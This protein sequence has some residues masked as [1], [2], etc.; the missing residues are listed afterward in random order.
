MK[1]VRGRSRHRA[2]TVGAMYTVDPEFPRRSHAD[3]VAVVHAVSPDLARE[4]RGRGF[5]V[6]YDAGFDLAA[7][8]RAVVGPVAAGVAEVMSMPLLVRQKMPEL[9]VGPY[10]LLAPVDEVA[11][12]VHRLRLA[13]LEWSA[14]RLAGAQRAGLAAVVSDPGHTRRPEVVE[15][16]LKTGLWVERLVRHV[17]PLSG[18]VAAV[19]SAA[20][21]VPAGC[22]SV[23][24]SEVSGLLAP[25]DQAAAVLRGRVRSVR[26][27]QLALRRCGPAAQQWLADR[28]RRRA[29]DAVAQLGFREKGVAL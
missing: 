29:A 13:A 6:C 19:L 1:R 22:S 27:E 21:V 14:K 11:A 3:S 2:A 15:G 25:L 23:V 16:D 20:P 5:E 18:V 12:E 7:E 10:P 28:E 24:D 8:V 17:E 26:A 9:Q 4:R